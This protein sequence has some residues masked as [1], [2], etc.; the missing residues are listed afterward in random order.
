[1]ATV[2]SLTQPARTALALPKF[3]E[4]LSLATSAGGALLGYNM[5]RKHKWLGAVVGLV[6]GNAA[7]T[8]LKSPVKKDA[9]IPVAAAAGAYFGTGL[10]RKYPV[11][12]FAAGLVAGGVAGSFAAKSV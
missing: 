6:G 5:W 3:A 9:L 11:A 8:L 4:P 1:M 7:Y 2:Q 12:G 10:V